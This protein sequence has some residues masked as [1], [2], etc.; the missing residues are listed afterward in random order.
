MARRP[1]NARHRGKSTHIWVTVR[2]AHQMSSSG[3][4]HI[5]PAPTASPPQLRAPGPALDCPWVD[6]PA[7][8]GVRRVR[9]RGRTEC[10]ALADNA[11]GSVVGDRRR[12]TR[13]G[14]RQGWVEPGA[15]APAARGYATRLVPRPHGSAAVALVRRA[16]VDRS[17]AKSLTASVSDSWADRS[18]NHLTC[19]AARTRT[20]EGHSAVARLPRRGRG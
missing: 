6:R 18:D 20:R 14:A 16:P 12:R 11:G 13:C 7:R 9:S 1:G 3:G 8:P 19:A 4:G 5:A 17:G 10:L 2:P 15:R